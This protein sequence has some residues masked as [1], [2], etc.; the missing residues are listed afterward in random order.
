MYIVHI[1]MIMMRMLE[2][3]VMMMFVHLVCLEAN[4]VHLLL[5][6]ERKV[7]VN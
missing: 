7:K 1:R 5:H 4:G 6:G 3:I 2:R